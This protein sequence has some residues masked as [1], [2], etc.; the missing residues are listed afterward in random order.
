MRGGGFRDAVKRCYKSKDK[1]RPN[2]ILMFFSPLVS[3]GYFLFNFLWLQNGHREH[4][5]TCTFLV[6]IMQKSL[7]FYDQI[8]WSSQ[9]LIIHS[10]YNPKVFIN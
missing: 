4:D 9:L 10:F 6:P 7:K 2:T 5:D 8:F 3:I 1:K